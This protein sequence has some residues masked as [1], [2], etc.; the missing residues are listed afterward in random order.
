MH[1]DCNVMEEP[2]SIES[3]NGKGK[4]GSNVMR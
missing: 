3:S 2:I 4:N 1:W